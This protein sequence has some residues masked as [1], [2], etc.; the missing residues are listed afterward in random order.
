MQHI[1][2]ELT[3]R[4][5]E[6]M[7]FYQSAWEHDPD[8]EIVNGCITGRDPDLEDYEGRMIL[9]F[10][11]LRDSVAT[12]PVPLMVYTQLLI[13]LLGPAQAEDVLEGLMREVG[14]KIFPATAAD[15]VQVLN[16]R[17]TAGDCSARH[18]R[19]ISCD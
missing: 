17:L 15:F 4:F 5:D 1:S 6:A 11:G 3:E 13:E 10:E 16:D 9:L 7:Y 14:R 2:A 18:L 19:S 12:A 8:M